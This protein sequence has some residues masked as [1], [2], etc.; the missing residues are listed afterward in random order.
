MPQHTGAAAAPRAVPATVLADPEWLRADLDTAARLY[1]GA[2]GRVLG[3]IRWY[4]ASS[5]LVAPAIE[6]LVLAGHALDPAL[7]ATTFAMHP[8]G[9][10]AGARS[11]RVLGPDPAELGAALA[12]SLGA[13]VAAI[14]G[15]SGAAERALWAIAGDSIGNRLLWAGTARG[16]V[17]RVL[18]L[19]EP[20]AA[21]I[22]PRL[23]RPRFLRV[24]DT[25]VLRRSSCCLIY[26]APGGGDKCV[27][28]PRQRPDERDRRLRELMG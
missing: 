13:A 18:A 15:V 5:V 16:D 7:A 14:A 25:P 6:G 1:G 9:R 2:D 21:R 19:A 4:S 26:L 8:D 27:S 3:T 28:C 23:P 20:L 17:E 24:G 12:E 22:D 10:F 11:A